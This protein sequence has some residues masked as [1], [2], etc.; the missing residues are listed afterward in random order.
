[1]EL[2][3]S[4]EIE[5]KERN[6][7]NLMQLFKYDSS[8][9]YNYLNLS[10][11]KTGLSLLV[12]F[13]LTLS[14][15]SFAKDIAPFDKE[16]QKKTIQ[17][18]MSQRQFADVS[19]F[20]INTGQYSADLLYRFGSATANVDFYQDRLVFSLRKMTK[21]LDLTT[22]EGLPEFEYVNWEIHLNSKDALVSHV[23]ETE[24]K[25]VNYF[26][27]DGNNI[28]RYQT[29][30]VIYK[31]VYPNIDLVFYQ[32][33][34]GAL[35]YDFILHKG[36]YLSDINLEYIGVEN[37]YLQ[38]TGQ[39][40]YSTKWGIVQEEKPFSYT[41]EGKNTVDIS[42][43]LRGNSL[44]FEGEEDLIRE[45]TVLD[46]I[47][48]DW[49]SY[50]YG[51]GNNGTSWAWTWV[52]DLDIDDSNNVYVTGMTNDR[53]PILANAYDTS[54]AGYYDGFV[55]KMS[56]DGDSILWF[57]YIGGSSYEYSFTLTVNSA[58]QPVIAGFSWSNDFPTTPGAWD[59][60]G[61]SGGT[62]WG[63]Y[64]GF[65][66]KFTDDGDSLVF[67]TFLGGASNDLI[68]S[69]TLDDGGNVYITG[70]TK[71]NDFPTTTGCYDP[72]YNGAA[73]G[74]GWQGG[75]AFLTKMNSNGTN[76]LFSTFIGGANDD[77]GYDIQL[78]PNN[79]IYI[80]G[81][82]GSGNFPVTPGSPIFNYNVLG[83]TDGFVMKFK[84]DGKTLVYSKLMGGNGDDWFESVYI[85]SYDEAYVA[86]IST[87]SDFYTTQNAYQT[88]NNGSADIVVV[89]MNALGQNVSYS[90][91]IG[92]SNAEQYWSGWIYNSNVSISANV[93]EEA[94]VCG[95]SRSTD[96]PVTSDA[97]YSNNP[98]GLGGGFYN[99][100]AV[101]FKLDY[102]GKNQLYGTYYGGSNFE[103][104]GANKLRRISCYTNILYGGIYKFVRLS[105][106]RMESTEKI[107]HQPL[108]AAFWTG[109]HI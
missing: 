58:H 14:L 81:K 64:K 60:N 83:N 89:K 48:V 67:S 98:S 88:S 57:S 4:E 71:S 42:Y 23:E 36:A 20:E 2:K 84:P 62:G 63:V 79:E 6:Y 35:K 24:S 70:E 90:T 40:S 26:D 51:S 106:Q 56:E 102:L 28:K 65:V 86:G 7:S 93:R 105:Q 92:G 109:F 103:I 68:H 18:K 101:I 107:N 53:F 78:S 74:W 49:S 72:S 104:P 8:L 29:T 3:L 13:F 16:Q 108:Q 27:K 46:P 66:T 12:L 54:P 22:P 1:M 43:S 17:E 9:S 37:L 85:N 32:S 96:F 91:Y 33:T 10:I 52:L 41:L 87:S 47:Y 25:G 21:G 69:M 99:T 61:G 5:K 19:A 100:S 11:V 82:T 95:I 39:L 59:R 80:V 77:V 15:N 30:K 97:L 45:E 44:S 73:G 34:E 50:F 75:D 76:L 55:C 94:I 38:S 31:E